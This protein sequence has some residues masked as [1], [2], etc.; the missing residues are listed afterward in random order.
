VNRRQNY[1]KY[2]NDS[3]RV[4]NGLWDL[5]VLICFVLLGPS[6]VAIVDQRRRSREEPS[7]HGGNVISQNERVV[8]LRHETTGLQRWH[9]IEE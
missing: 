4:P 7:W 8:V 9:V 3:L 2:T 1:G 5:W 6:N